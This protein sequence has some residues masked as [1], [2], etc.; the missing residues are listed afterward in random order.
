M[1]DDFDQD[2]LPWEACLN[3]GSSALGLLLSL[4]G[5]PL[6]VVHAS[7]HGSVWQVVSVSI[8]GAT[9]VL[10]YLAFTLYHQ[11]KTSRFHT[12]FKILD[13]ATIYLLIAGSYTPF[14]LVNLR[15][16]GG[17]WLFGVVWGVALGGIVFKVFFVYRFRV[18]APL[19]YVA[20]GWLLVFAVK[21]ALLYIAK[22]V[23]WLL[24]IGGLLYTGGLLFYA[25]KRIPYHH[26][27][28]HLFVVGGSLCHF[29]A[30][31]QNVTLL[32]G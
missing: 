20:M 9:L 2:R 27:I 21:P 5:L 12:L 17:W 14:I 32:P 11:F 30:V 29:F 7:H 28:W 18:V 25:F 6:V 19:L 26:A 13:H 8:Y 22:P 3:T 4:A 31:F 15:E 16:H 10:S 23:L 1:S 24:L